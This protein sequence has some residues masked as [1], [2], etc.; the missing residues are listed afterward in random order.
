MQKFPFLKILKLQ[1]K[2]EILIIVRAKDTPPTFSAPNPAPVAK[3]L[4]TLKAASS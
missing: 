2:N 1:N 4:Q 3:V